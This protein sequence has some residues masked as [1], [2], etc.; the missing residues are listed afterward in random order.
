ML[1][2]IN[3]LGFQNTPNAPYLH[4]DSKKSAIK[5]ENVTFSYGPGKEIFKDLNLVIEPGKKVAIVGG[6]GSG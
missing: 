3:V 5:F 4:V 1:N 2:F 6:S